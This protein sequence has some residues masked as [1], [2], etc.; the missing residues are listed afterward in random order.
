[1]KRIFTVSLLFLCVFVVYGTA[2]S[3]S[4]KVLFALNKAI[5]DPALANNAASMEKF[6]DGISAAVKSGN[7]DHIAVYGY[8]SPEGPLL[9]NDR[10]SVRRCEVIADY[11]S[12]HADVPL[13]Y[14]NTCP[15]YMAWEGL[16]TLVIEDPRTPSR[17]EVL[18]VLDEYLPDACTDHALSEQ[19]RKSLVAIDN[20]RTY[21]WMLRNLFPKLRFSLAVYAYHVAE[22]A[23]N[24]PVETHRNIELNIIKLTPP[25][26]DICEE[27]VFSAPSY[28][29]YPDGVS[30]LPRHRLA[31]KT[32]LLYDAVLLPD[33]EVEWRVNDRWSVALEGDVAWWGN[34]SKEKSYKL[35]MGSPEVRRWFLTRA[36]WH[37]L[38]VGLFA[39]G[40]YYD[41][42][43][44][45]KGYRGEGVMGGL[46]VG[47]MWP[48]SRCLSLEAAVG[49]G[50]LYTRCKEYKPLEGCHVYQRTKNINY[51]GPLKL[52]FSLVWRLWDV[53]RSRR[54][55]A[56][57]RS[58]RV[59]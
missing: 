15:G 29:D 47:Y 8:A 32:N 6:V 16:R 12:R 42:E 24:N 22:R 57:S 51:F 39:G 52:K 38:F 40:G 26:V 56:E 20:G 11:I 49:A 46:S 7:L 58:K 55:N 30:L 48:V 53:N 37:G 13:D 45:T 9:N 33:L 50:Y 10:L 28:I 34:G 17:D 27:V 59:I 41:L 23:V 3:D 2:K 14:I 18:T 54:L 5:Y 31:L 1:M 43:N 25:R 19:C 21:D 35:L 4:I 36:P 44:V